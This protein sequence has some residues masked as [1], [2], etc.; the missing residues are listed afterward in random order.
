MD[1][2]ER[3]ISPDIIRTAAALL[4]F[5]YHVNIEL[6]VKGTAASWNSIDAG[7]NIELGQLGTVLLFLLF[8]LPQ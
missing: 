7:A 1:K 3:S 4:V 6:T 8:R 5:M 2:K